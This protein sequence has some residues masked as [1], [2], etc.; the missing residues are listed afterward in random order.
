M[1]LLSV[2]KGFKPFLRRCH[3]LPA[4][5]AVTAIVLVQP[6]EQIQ[7]ALQSHRGIQAHPEGA[8]EAYAIH[9][10]SPQIFAPPIAQ[11]FAT[12]GSSTRSLPTTTSSSLRSRQRTLP[13][14]GEDHSAA[15]IEYDGR[16]YRFAGVLGEGAY[17]TVKLAYDGLNQPH[18][19]VSDIRNE[20]EA[21]KNVS[22][23]GSP[24]LACMEDFFQD[25]DFCY[26][27]M[28][29]GLAVSCIWPIS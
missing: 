18:G 12:A 23:T 19:Y 21:L 4:E 2:P 14:R 6:L 3:L 27:V 10:P 29:S 7:S 9:H 25:Y 20:C 28:V 16:V 13:Q 1:P 22:A 8:A 24:F 15:L 17:G 26:M 5:N 11:T